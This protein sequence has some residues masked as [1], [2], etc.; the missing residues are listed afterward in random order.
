MDKIAILVLAAGKSSRMKAIKQ[1]LKIKNKTLLEL[2]LEKAVQL[3][4][5]TIFCVLGA[6]S[7]KIKSETRTEN[8]TFIQNKN[9]EKGLSSSIVTGLKYFEKKQLFFD[10]ILILLADQPQI[11]IS[12]LE[13]LVKNHKENPNKIIV[14]SYGNKVGVPS[15][16]PKKYFDKLFN[17]KGDKGAK[18]FIQ[19]NILETIIVK[20]KKPL[21]DLDTQEDYELY[22]KSI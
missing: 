9:Y 6:H 15:I 22:L 16:F 10:A 1:L 3:E 20:T 14:T 8:I 4:K 18:E 11:T 17:L 12:F 21:I 7:K 2:T 13:T 5:T 19:K